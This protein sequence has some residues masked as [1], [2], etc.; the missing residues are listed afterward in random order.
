MPHIYSEV[1]VTCGDG[2]MRNKIGTMEEWQHRLE[3]LGFCR[4]QSCTC[5]GTRAALPFSTRLHPF[6]DL[7]TKVDPCSAAQLLPPCPTYP[8]LLQHGPI[9]AARRLDRTNN[10]QLRSRH[11]NSPRR[12]RTD[13]SGWGF[14]DTNTMA[15]NRKYAALPDL[16][17]LRTRK[18]TSCPADRLPP[19]PGLGARHLRDARTYRRPVDN[20]GEF[21]WTVRGTQLILSKADDCAVSF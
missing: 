14:C 5:C 12:F 9:C 6:A 1:R 16:V 19:L 11:R 4:S 20:S 3:R 10:L 2:V 7:K 8:C 13:L 18:L 15:S 21:T 17:G